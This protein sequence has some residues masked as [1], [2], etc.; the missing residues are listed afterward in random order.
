MVLG[1]IL[2]L[3]FSKIMVKKIFLRNALAYRPNKL[4]EKCRKKYLQSN[5]FNAIYF[6][7]KNRK[8]DKSSEIDYF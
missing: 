4:H 3:I 1:F 6:N 8:S 2:H 7:F 5:Y